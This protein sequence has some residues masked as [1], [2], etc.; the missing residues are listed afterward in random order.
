MPRQLTQGEQE[1]LIDYMR[2]MKADEAFVKKYGNY[3]DVGDNIIIEPRILG[4]VPVIGENFEQ[5]PPEFQ[6]QVIRGGRLRDEASFMGAPSSGSLVTPNQSRFGLLSGDMPYN[7]IMDPTTR[8][9]LSPNQEVAAMEAAQGAERVIPDVSNGTGLRSEGRLGLQADA[10]SLPYQAAPTVTTMPAPNMPEESN[11]GVFAGL[12]NA[13]G[14][15]ADRVAQK[16][17]FTQNATNQ[18]AVNPLQTATQAG[19]TYQ[20]SKPVNAGFLAAQ[21]YPTDNR[22]RPDLAPEV[23]PFDPQNPDIMSVESFDPV[24]AERQRDLRDAEAAQQQSRLVEGSFDGDLGFN[25]EYPIVSSNPQT[26]SN[27]ANKQISQLKSLN[28]PPEVISDLEGKKNAAESTP[29]DPYKWQNFFAAAAIA[30]D[31]LRMPS[32]RNPA[33]VK[34]MQDRINFNRALTRGN[35]TAAAIEASGHKDAKMLADAVRQGTITA[36]DAFTIISKNP[37]QIQTAMQLIQDGDFGMLEQLSKAGVFQSQGVLQ[38]DK[39]ARDFA[40]NTLK[41]MQKERITAA[42]SIRGKK[43]AL[44]QLM[45]LSKEI[46]AEKIGTAQFNNQLLQL[47][48]TLESLGLP[49][50][51]TGEIKT[52]DQFN[53]VVNQLVLEELRSNKG[54]QTDFDAIFAGTT[55][56]NAG[57]SLE[58]NMRILNYL[59]AQNEWSLTVNKYLN[60]VFAGATSDPQKAAAMAPK[61]ELWFAE[62]VPGGIDM[63]NG[64]VVFFGE[65]KRKAKQ[66]DRSKTDLDIVHEWIKLDAEMNGEMNYDDIPHP[67]KT[68]GIKG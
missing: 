21:T 2:G 29:S 38:E 63:G 23:G 48:R 46:D 5:L 58:A 26:N 27:N 15:I 13:V 62:N 40:Y 18:N 31:N 17:G 37:T 68:L 22:L 60:E 42:K 53:A 3:L 34:T 24:E 35:R 6:Q 30:F 39:A 44:S 49:S 45:T 4:M 51:L 10:S 41:E 7:A 8:Q 57:N 56:P 67:S 9:Q 55:L 52:L 64:T 25:K 61:I 28:L 19:G 11:K 59:D 12:L 36:K 1:Y 20:E 33:L 66:K 50:G 47:G 16:R 14:G 65:F 32:M 54:P 43:V